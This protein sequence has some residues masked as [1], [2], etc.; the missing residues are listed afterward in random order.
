MARVLCLS[1]QV[2][3]GPVGNSA[4][5]PAL[6]AQGHEV[7]ALPTI[8]LSHH[9]GH[10]PP[11]M[12]RHSADSFSNMLIS[13]EKAGGLENCAAVLT[14]YFS[15]VDQITTTAKLLHRLKM[16][17]PA[18]MVLVDPVL[19]D[20]GKLYVAEAIAHAIHDQLLPLATITTPN[21]FELS[22]LT[23]QTVV[24]ASEAAAAAQSLKID[25][26]LVTSIPMENQMLGTL[27][28]S[29]NMSQMIQTVKH[30]HVPNGTGDYLAGAYLAARLADAPEIAFPIAMQNL[31]RVISASFGSKV[32][33]NV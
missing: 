4:L 21:L 29:K 1:S 24:T 11:S 30:D 12:L 3:F 15:T 32:L 14:G 25:E 26:V 9:P 18:L 22:F 8:V 7:L 13:V 5:V 31:A 19:G 6:Q 16:Q 27:L 2:V 28:Q 33:V 23:G 20:N 10:G 17:N